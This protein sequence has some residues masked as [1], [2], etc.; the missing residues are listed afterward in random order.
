[1][2]VKDLLEHWD[3]LI[4]LIPLPA[5]WLRANIK[6]KGVK[7]IHCAH[8]TVPRTSKHVDD[9]LLLAS[10]SGKIH[11]DSTHLHNFA[12]GLNLKSVSSSEQILEVIVFLRENI[13]GKRSSTSNPAV[14]VESGEEEDASLCSSKRRALHFASNKVAMTLLAL[15]TSKEAFPLNEAPI[16]IQLQRQAKAVKDSI[17][18]ITDD[19]EEHETNKV[20]TSKKRPNVLHVGPSL[21]LALRKPTLYVA[22]TTRHESQLARLLPPAPFGR[23]LPLAPLLPSLLVSRGVIRSTNK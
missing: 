9:S 2:F 11:H 20:V 17:S 15:R 3:K 14:I 22:E 21:T 1:M 19:E 18:S 23:P 4:L 12:V 8:E 5:V 10:R 16:P 13:M 7:D 6:N